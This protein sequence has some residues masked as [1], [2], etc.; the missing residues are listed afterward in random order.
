MQLQVP[1][2]YRY[3]VD[4]KRKRGS[5]NTALGVSLKG[6]D[7]E[8]MWKGFVDSGAFCVGGPEQV[9]EKVQRYRAAGADRLVS[10]MQLADLRHEDLMRSIELMGTKVIPTIRASEVATS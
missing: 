6:E 2:S 3:H 4:M 1:D 8:A 10:V 9:I 5:A 7:K